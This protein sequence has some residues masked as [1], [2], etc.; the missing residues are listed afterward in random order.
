MY[1]AIL[2]GK[3]E[4][5]M[6]STRNLTIIFFAKTI[7]QIL[8]MSKNRTLVNFQYL[9]EKLK[10][11]H[12]FSSPANISSIQ[13]YSEAKTNKKPKINNTTNQH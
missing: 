7:S 10:T 9:K 13:T 1:E 12:I 2:F 3:K 11:P 6:S 8:Q 4:Y 5:S